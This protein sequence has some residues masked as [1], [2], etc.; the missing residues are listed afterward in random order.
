MSKDRAF[1]MTHHDTSSR[2]KISIA[3]MIFIKFDDLEFN[4]DLMK[5]KELN[6]Q[7]QKMF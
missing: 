2:F 6:N 7:R 1:D 5:K 4:D 3:T